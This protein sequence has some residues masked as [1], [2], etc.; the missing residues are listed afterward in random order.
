MWIPGRDNSE[1]TGIEG[2]K[3][4]SKAGK[5]GIYNASGVL[6]GSD[7]QSI[8][9]LPAGLYIVNDGQKTKKVIVK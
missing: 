2:I 1:T 8:D 4:N 5:V 7:L 9:N 6:V 3:A